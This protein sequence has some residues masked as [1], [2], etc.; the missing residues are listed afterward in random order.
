MSQRVLVVVG[1]VTA[2]YFALNL[3]FV[4]QLHTRD[5]IAEVD[6]QT[7][8]HRARHRD[9]TTVVIGSVPKY[10]TAPPVVRPKPTPPVVAQHLPGIQ[11]DATG[12]DAGGDNVVE[13]SPRVRPPPGTATP[14]QPSPSSHP[15]AV[16]PAPTRPQAVDETNAGVGKRPLLL[17]RTR[18]REPSGFSQEAIDFVRGLSRHYYVGLQMEGNTIDGY[19]ASWSPELRAMIDRYH[20]REGYILARPH[21][22]IHHGAAGDFFCDDKPERPMFCIGRA[23]FETDRVP[24]GWVDNLQTQDQIWVP[25]QFNVFTFARS[26][27]D[28]AKLMVVPEP[29]NVTLFDPDTTTPL[30]LNTGKSYHFLAVYAWNDRK[31]YIATLI[32]E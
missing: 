14:E 1:I 27:L 5:S 31:V 22:L 9:R 30:R 12:E 32:R 2:L 4:T 16:P 8:L 25:S 29:M 11:N 17:Y 21:T 7:T 10:G 18:F 24:F 3:M 26:G 19:V 13:V 15:P 20:A 6:W 28:P 23:M